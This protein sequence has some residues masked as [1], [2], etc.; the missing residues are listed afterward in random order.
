MAKPGV[1]TLDLDRAAE[2]ACRRRG[3]TPAFKGL[4]GFP[5]CLCVAVN[6]VVVHGIPSR[7]VVL[8]KGDIIGLDFGVVY[9]NWYGD[10]ARTV[11][12]GEIDEASAQLIEATERSMNAGIAACAAGVELNAIGRAVSA[13]ADAGGYGVVRDFLGH[14][15]GRKLHEEP[16]VPNYFDTRA[17]MRLRSG[18]VI[19]IE[20]MLNA[21]TC[22]VSTLEDGW[23]AVTDDHARS[24]HF[25]HTVAITDSGPVVLSTPGYGVKAA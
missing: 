10:H 25:E 11:A 5:G 7:K 8:R 16:Q 23:T 19:C 13:V 24:A 4:Y 12:V 22:D 3:V 9:K 20:P 18:M 1:S 2:E 17:R 14:G 15:I 6:E 21:G